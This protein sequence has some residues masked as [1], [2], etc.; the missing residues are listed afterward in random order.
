[1]RSEDK[2]VSLETAKKLK[3]NGFSQDTEHKWRFNKGDYELV[4]SSDKKNGVANFTVFG[5]PHLLAAPDAQ[6]IGE[7]LPGSI[8]YDQDG[9]HGA[10][11]CF[12]KHSA[13][14]HNSS[15]QIIVR[16]DIGEVCFM[17]KNLAEALAKMWLYLKEN[18]LID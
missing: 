18:K 9:Y 17:G 15:G 10:C 5:K 8:P 14:Y 4:L 16:D 2:V 6:E 7:M 1:M 13:F 3:E 11:L 12:D